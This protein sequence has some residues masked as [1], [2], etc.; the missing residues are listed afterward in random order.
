MRTLLSGA[1]GREM[2]RTLSGVSAGQYFEHGEWSLLVSKVTAPL[3]ASSA[4]AAFFGDPRAPA[5]RG[6]CQLSHSRRQAAS[7][8]AWSMSVRAARTISA[9]NIRSIFARPFASSMR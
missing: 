3:P 2:R 1:I 8:A 9:A 5:D 7:T 4:A 6:G